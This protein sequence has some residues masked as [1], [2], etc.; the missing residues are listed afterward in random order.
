MP[1]T[2]YSLLS[3]PFVT[4]TPTYDSQLDTRAMVLNLSHAATLYYSL[5]C[6]S[7]S[8]IKLSLLLLHHYNF[9]T[10]IYCNVN[11]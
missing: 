1:Y 11:I 8:I 10:I 6:C 7:D 2:T 9:A 4:N 3:P 5:L